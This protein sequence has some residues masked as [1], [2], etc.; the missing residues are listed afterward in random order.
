MRAL[1]ILWAVIAVGCAGGPEQAA[2]VATAVVDALPVIDAQGLAA[3]ERELTACPD[4]SCA[5]RVQASWAP[6]IDAMQTIREA[7]C[8]ADPKKPECAK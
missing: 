3:Y 5:A 2:R 8:E 7:I 4:E 1:V 6:Y